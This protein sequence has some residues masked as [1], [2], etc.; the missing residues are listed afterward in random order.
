MAVSGILS[1]SA[2]DTPIMGWSSWNTYRVNISDSLIM[3][4]ADAMVR[5]GLDS[6]GYEFINIDDGYFGGRDSITGELLV[7]PMRFPGGLRPVVD[8]IHSLGLRA[9]IYSDAGVSTCGFNWDNDTIARN[10]GLYGHEYQDCKLFFDSLGFD[11]IKVDYCGGTARQNKAHLSFDPEKRYRIIRDAIKASGRDDVLLNVCRWDYPGTWVGDVADSWRISTDIN[12][13]W[14]SVKGIINQNLYLS[15]YAL[16]GH[17]DMDMLEVG[18]SMTP[19]ED[20]THFAMWCIMS[21]PLLVG[22]DMRNMKPETVELLKNTELIALN[23]DPLGLQ[24][25]V[26]AT[27]GHTYVLVKDIEKPYSTVRAVA[28]YNPS[29]SVRNVDLR[30]SDIDLDG[31]VVLRD[32]FEHQEIGKFKD[33]FSIDVPPHG[34][35]I[36]RAEAENRLE[37]KIY[38]GET[39]YL[40]A[41]QELYNPIA[42]GTG[43]YLADTRCSGGM[44]A[45][46]LGLTP[47]NDIVWRDVHSFSGGEYEL[48]FD[49]IS[50]GGRDM[51]VSANDG[52]GRLIK[53]PDTGGH[54]SAIAVKAMLKPGINIVRL[55]NDGA[56]MPDIDR[57]TLSPVK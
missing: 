7:H 42:V 27:D 10:V 17:N 35:K 12:C 32:L 56:L 38:E 20:R 26:A 15:A 37:R 47:V 1:I 54:V 46:N 3:S 13:S 22:C 19:E 5:H 21:S 53:V 40:S 30:F 49:V 11:F 4:Q 24:A 43:N 8:H 41:Y 33:V 51:Y 50:E 23:Q 52:E 16:G 31:S 25:Y 57:M 36:Y 6:V 28:L 45:A 29:D 14:K 2:K 18:R 39:A 48:T 55:Y 9:G 34:V 44:K